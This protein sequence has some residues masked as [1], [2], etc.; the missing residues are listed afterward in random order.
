[1]ANLKDLIVRGVSRFIGKTYV[2]DIDISGD[3]TG[4]AIDSAPT[5][6][7]DK[8]VTSGGIYTAI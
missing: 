1:M 7:S 2:D 8:L 4:N 3:V 6:G 5:S